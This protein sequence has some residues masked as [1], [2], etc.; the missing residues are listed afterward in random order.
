MIEISFSEDK[1]E[2]EEKAQRPRSAFP[3]ARRMIYLHIIY[4]FGEFCKDNS[5]LREEDIYI[6]NLLCV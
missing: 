3:V 1:E 2:G 5:S 4:N 6:W